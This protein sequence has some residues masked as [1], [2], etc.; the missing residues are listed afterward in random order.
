[1]KERHGAI[2]GLRMIA[3]IGIMMMHMQANNGYKIDGY[4]Y[5]TVIPSFTNFVFL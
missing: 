5:N 4:F 2:D 1:M 3:C